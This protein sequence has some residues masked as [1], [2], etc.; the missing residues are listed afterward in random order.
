MLNNLLYN[1]PV[2]TGCFKDKIRLCYL[3]RCFDRVLMH[4]AQAVTFAPLGKVTDCKLG[5]CF[6]L[7]VGLNLVARKRTRDQT[8]LPFLAQISQTFAIFLFG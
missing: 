4:L 7:T 8:T 2:K 5:C 6:R 3:L 1:N